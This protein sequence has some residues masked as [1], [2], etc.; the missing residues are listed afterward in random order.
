MNL[1]PTQG[2]VLKLFLGSSCAISSTT[3]LS[4]TSKSSRFGQ[5]LKLFLGSSYAILSTAA[6]HSPAVHIARA[7]GSTELVELLVG[8]GAQPHRNFDRCMPCERYVVGPRLS[9]QQP[10]LPHQ[11]HNSTNHTPISNHTH[12]TNHTHQQPLHS[13]SSTTLT[14]TPHRAPY[15][16]T[17]QQQHR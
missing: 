15:Q 6:V 12:R 14:S 13:S 7:V 17:T 1:G 16:T 11:P 3:T 9:A 5:V 2:Q 8:M 4:L 10:H